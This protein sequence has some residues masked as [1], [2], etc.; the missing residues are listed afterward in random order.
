MGG[1][2]RGGERDES[3]LTI[4]FSRKE[5][6]NYFKKLAKRLANIERN[7]ESKINHPPKTK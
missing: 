7:R 2:R 5:L 4:F 3:E 1:K 6:A